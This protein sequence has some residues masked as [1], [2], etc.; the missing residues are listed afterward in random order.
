MTYQLIKTKEKG[1]K[2]PPSKSTQYY[3]FFRTANVR[4]YTSF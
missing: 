3:I 4:L 1:I 2:K